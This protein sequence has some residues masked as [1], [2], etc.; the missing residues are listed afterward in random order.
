MNRKVQGAR[1]NRKAI[2]TAV[3]RALSG[4]ALTKVELQ[5]ACPQ[6]VID[7]NTL[8][9]LRNSGAITVT[10]GRYAKISLACPVQLLWVRFEEFLIGMKRNSEKEEA[11]E[12]R[13]LTEKSELKA[14][15]KRSEKKIK[16]L[17]EELDMVYTE[18][19]KL[20]VENKKL[21]SII[22]NIKE[23]LK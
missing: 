15:F 17:Q 3:G 10:R 11:V 18:I 22:T 1:E 14:A 12:R 21:K 5:E 2:L 23:A 16:D 7:N 13:V 6:V 9:M 8:E 4:H 20:E 19:G